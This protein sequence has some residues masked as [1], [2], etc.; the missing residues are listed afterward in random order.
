MSNSNFPTATTENPEPRKN[1][2]NVIIGIFS[3]AFLV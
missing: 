1:F 2:K 3:V